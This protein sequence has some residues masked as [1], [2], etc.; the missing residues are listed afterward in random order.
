[1]WIQSVSVLI[2]VATVGSVI[3]GTMALDCTKM[4][5]CGADYKCKNSSAIQSC[6]NFQVFSESRQACVNPEFVSACNK[7]VPGWYSPI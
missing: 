6:E 1:M 2:A 3:Q 7:R 5:S 4:S